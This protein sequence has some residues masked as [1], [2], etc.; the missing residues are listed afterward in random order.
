M[1]IGHCERIIEPMVSLTR[2]VEFLDHIRATI[3]FLR[4]ILPHGFSLSLVLSVVL[5]FF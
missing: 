4:W 2:F 1:D 3:S 5:S